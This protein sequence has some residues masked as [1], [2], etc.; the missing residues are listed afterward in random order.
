MINE[1]RMAEEFC[2]LVSIDSP[3]YGERNITDV[4]KRKLEALGFAVKE[5]DAASKIGGT[6]GNLYAYLEGGIP[7][8]PILFCGHTDT[9]E[10][11][12]GK[13]PVRHEDGRITS[14]GDTVLGGDDLC[15]VVEI[16][17]GVRH[18]REEG[19]PHRSVEV[20]LMAAEEVFGKGAKA[21]DYGTWKFR[22]EEAYV[23]DMSGPAGSAA[24]SAPTL[25]GWEAQITGK[26]A[27]AGFSPEKGVSAIAVA[28]GAV[29]GLTT[30]W[31]GDNATLNVGTIQGGRANNIVPDKCTV[32]GEVRSL[33]HEK[34]LRII[35]DIK[36]AF[37]EQAGDARIDFTVD[38]HL[39]AYDTPEEHP[40]V[41]R[42]QRAC[43]KRNL[44]GKTVST[45]GG[46]DNN[47]L[48]LHGLTG[49]VLSCGMYQVHSTKEYTSVQDLK[50]GAELVA[51]LLQD[52]E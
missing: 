21:Y 41:K 7:A 10:P 42:F 25:I 29:A 27:H 1:E 8:E 45:L 4:I 34:A 24:L 17:E 5:D 31:I 51:E 48:R 46:S 50:K 14:A 37:L 39:V 12:R 49:I 11:A 2:E 13:T 36:N 32:K 35:E 16:L 6:A 44:P 19:L 40:V 20:V 30:G 28:A 9:V 52:A 22:S 43:R 3:S 23:L 38:P 47:I 18:L 26:A 33:D 15:G